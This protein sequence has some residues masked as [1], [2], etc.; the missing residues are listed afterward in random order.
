MIALVNRKGMVYGLL[1]S[2]RS[3]DDCL[4]HGPSGQRGTAFS[5]T[6]SSARLPAQRCE[7][8]P[9]TAGHT[10]RFGAEASN[11]LLGADDAAQGWFGAVRGGEDEKS[12]IFF[13]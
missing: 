3:A 6:A 10:A 2:R 11:S 12:T 13:V 7:Q 9:E 8:E 1:Q 4:W 5:D